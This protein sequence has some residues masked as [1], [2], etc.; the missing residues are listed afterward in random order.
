MSN[1]WQLSDAAYAAYPRLNLTIFFRVTSSA[2][3]QAYDNPSVN[4]ATLK[5]MGYW[6]TWI[7][8]E[9]YIYWWVSAINP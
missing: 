3:G 8:Q 7:H 6:I 1:D 4:E 9:M 5:N 2:L